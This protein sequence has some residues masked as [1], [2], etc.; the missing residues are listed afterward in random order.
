MTS[1]LK[2]CHRGQ[3]HVDGIALVEYLMTQGGA[4]QRTNEALALVL[5]LTRTLAGFTI[6]D[7]ARFVQARNHVKDGIDAN[8]KPCCGYRLN[9]KHSG[10]GA[11][12]VLVDPVGA[13]G[14]HAIATAESLIGWL[15]IEAQRA[16]ENL[17]MAENLTAL[18]D[19]ALNQNP[20]DKRGYRI[21]TQAATE[22]VNDGFLRA[23]TR[24]ELMLWLDDIRS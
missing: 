18:G 10:R 16:T 3:T 1:I 21:C 9:Y 17:R 12:L 22:I 13:H 5:G 4:A 8:G 2:R 15:Q 19:E 24:A 7:E 23:T 11:A 6:A 14:A 20:P